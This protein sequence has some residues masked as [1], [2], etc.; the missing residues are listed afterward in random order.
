MSIILTYF[1]DPG[2]NDY[3]FDDPDY[4]RCYLELG[5]AVEKLGSE[6]WIVR[7]ADTYKGKMTF[8]SG[9]KFSEGKFRDVASP[10]K[11]NLIYNKGRNLRTGARDHL[12]NPAGLDA[13]CGLDKHRTFEVFPTLF[14][15]TAEVK[16]VDELKSAVNSMK[17]EWVVVKPV[18][19]FGGKGVFI[20]PKQEASAQAYDYPVIVQEFVDTSN[21]IDG[22]TPSHHDFRMIIM[23]GEVFM[24]FLRTPP[25]G[26]LLSNVAQGGSMSVVPENMRPQGAL[27]LIAEVE[28]KLTVFEH[29]L[30]TIDCGYDSAHK[31]WYVFELN[32]QPGLVTPEECGPF[33]DEY[34]ER[35]AQYLIE[36]AKK[37]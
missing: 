26:K 16:S 27:D 36:C 37:R 28:N 19:G 32:D 17:T 7:S 20:G 18:S 10:I 31:K 14:P 8:S 9:W 21:G 24:T 13:A 6:L 1:D 3:P 30:Y 11:G 22:L 4:V 29:R 35:L 5:N 33:K 12:I 34:Y 15:T 23:D 25:E 2:F